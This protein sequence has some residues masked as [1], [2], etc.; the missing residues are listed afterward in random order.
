M[1]LLLLALSALLAAACGSDGGAGGT[2]PPPDAAV[3]QGCAPTPAT[4][5]CVV[6]AVPA[7]ARARLGL[8]AFYEKYVD[9]EGFPIVSSSKTSDRALCEARRLVVELLAQRPELVARLNDRKIRLAIMATTELT[10]DIP[11]HSDLT[12]KDYWDQR[13]RGLG[14]TLARP[15]VSAA[16]EN[17]VCAPPGQDRYRGENILIHEFS[18]AIF[19]IAIDL[20]EPAVK[21]QLDAAYAAAIAAGRFTNTYAATNRDEYCAEG[22]QDWFDTNAVAIPSNGIHNE[23]HTRTQLETYD[24]GL[25][26]LEAAV[27]GRRP[28]RYSCP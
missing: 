14:A 26:A 9:H 27:F 22:A 7:C 23:I 21:D 24:P 10:T 2:P 5:A 11:E 4:A 3:D 20:Y 28:W 8:A 25:A 6:R 15:A 16:E 18:H 19:N 13:A 12:P 1:L 17:L